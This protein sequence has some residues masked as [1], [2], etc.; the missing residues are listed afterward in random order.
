MF[1]AILFFVAKLAKIE[2]YT[3]IDNVNNHSYVTF[4]ISSGRRQCTAS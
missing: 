1:T 3:R 4:S 2:L